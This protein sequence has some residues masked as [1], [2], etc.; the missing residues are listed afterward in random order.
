MAEMAQIGILAAAASAAAMAFFAA[1][2]AGK[3]I[4]SRRAAARLAAFQVSGGRDI[5]PVSEAFRIRLALPFAPEGREA[6][7]FLAFRLAAA[8]LA[9]GAL[10]FLGLPPVMAL[11]AGLLGYLAAEEFVRSRWERF[12]REV[13]AGL[14]VFLE[15]MA[16]M[17]QITPHILV[18]VGELAEA[19][20][21]SPLRAWLE[22]FLARARQ[23]EWAAME[24]EA[25]RISPSL[26]LAIFLVRRAHETGGPG[27]GQALAAAASRLSGI[28]AAREAAR[29]K[30]EGVMGAVRTM[31]LALAGVLFL[32]LGNPMI[33][34]AVAHPFVQIGYAAAMGVAGYG[35]F[36]IRDM[37]REA[38]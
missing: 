25:S 24:E 12:V 32:F 9:A 34:E 13:E 33:R 28:L 20:E 35:F 38:I 30:A 16:A 1:R 15:R 7:T 11:A 6:E 18:A 5:P 14:P 2:A 17:I 27:Y 26:G 4:V 37:V 21:E 29:A 31:A 3:W 8:G 10:L 19:M 23:G 22:R 36:F